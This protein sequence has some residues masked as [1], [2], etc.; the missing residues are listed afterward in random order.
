MATPVIHVIVRDKNGITAE[1]DYTAVSSYNEKGLFDVLPFHTNFI[2]LIK[3]KLVLHKGREEKEIKVGT[4]LLRVEKNL[5][6]IYLGL[7]ESSG[8]SETA[9]IAKPLQINTLLKQ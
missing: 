3:T 7:P 2:S 4:G 1:D 5:V 8:T 6:S 9:V